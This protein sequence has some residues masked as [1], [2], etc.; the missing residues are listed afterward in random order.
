MK[1]KRILAALAKGGLIVAERQTGKTTAL[2]EYVRQRGPAQFVVVASSAEQ[3]AYLLWKWERVYPG[4]APPQFV[5]SFRFKVAMV[6]LRKRVVV[7]EYF[8]CAFTEPFEVAVAS[9]LFPV[10]VIK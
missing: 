2:L 7:D 9:T 10:T 4:I 1:T 6:G 5:P 8:L 3:A